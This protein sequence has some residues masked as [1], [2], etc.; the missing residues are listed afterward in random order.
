[1]LLQ[2]V[3]KFLPDCK[4]SH[5]QDGSLLFNFIAMRAVHHI[6]YVFNKRC[7]DKCNSISLLGLCF[8]RNE[9]ISPSIKAKVIP[10]S[11]PSSEI[12]D[13]I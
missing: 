10:V 4:M 5:M 7:A 8:F 2:H 11:L 13:V 12:P 9:S 6:L 3:N 1:M